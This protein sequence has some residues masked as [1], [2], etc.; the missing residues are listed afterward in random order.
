[1]KIAVAQINSCLG[2]FAYNADK[3]L[4]FI[5]QANKAGCDL[6]VFPEA[7][8]F[9]YHPFDLL[10]R[11]C[12]I[13]AQMRCLNHIHRKMPKGIAAIVGC[14]EK[15]H[16][17]KGR[18]YFNS[19]ALLEKGKE[20]KFFHKQL[21]PTGDVFDEGRFIERG[22]TENNF[23]NF[24]KK[25]F[26]V[27][28]CEDIWAWPTE[29]GYSAYA[30]NPLAK[31][32]AK[33]DLVINLSASPFYHGKQHL[34]EDCVK[35]TAAHFSAPMIY[36]NLVGAQDELIYD[37]GSFGVSA[38]GR[39]IL[40][41][42]HFEEDFKVLDFNK[43]KFGS[44]ACPFSGIESV[45]KALVLGIRDF[46]EKIGIQKVH[47]GLSG[48]ID[49]AVVAC[50]AVDALGAKAVSAL[51][52]TG[53][54][55]THESQKLAAQLATNL[56]ISFK[57]IDFKSLYGSANEL[58]ASEL[59]ATEFGLVQ[60]NIQARLRA[61]LLMAYSNLHNSLLL[62]TSNKS[63][64]ACGFS[65]LYGDQCGGLSPL[66]DLTKDQVYHLAEF[67]NL[68]E[69]KIPFE[70]ISR[71]PSA[72]LRPGQKD[73]DTLPKY[74]ILD[75]AVR[76]IVERSRSATLPEEKWLLHRLF[77]S[78]FKRWQGPPVLKVSS[79]AFGRGRRFPIAHRLKY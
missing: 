3:I 51:A 16:L 74:E 79:H 32:K 40:K 35:R 59:K 4:K 49:S 76:K 13:D 19:A 64:L 29:R 61:I 72:E 20:P 15:T 66:G 65:T 42:K 28:I 6:V 41:C 60:E 17:K 58:L 11:A 45:Q 50:L 31:I 47:L 70:I 1:M 78:E 22:R 44:S 63:E 37:G 71:A 54:Y 62:N 46:C 38:S 24:K 12:A 67:Y 26:L 77:A 7:S 27:T 10:E 5:G 2:D 33:V 57:D 52:L 23:F 39:N 21:L 8:L 73:E 34:R 25:K 55:T 30:E 43:P 68:P 53:P 75:H 48:G 14:F 9:G 18:P 69:E 36:V 56:G